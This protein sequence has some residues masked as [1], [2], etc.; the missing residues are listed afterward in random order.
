MQS[1]VS[2]SLNPSYKLTTALLVYGSAVATVHQPIVTNGRITLGKGTPL[3]EEALRDLIRTV[4]PN[5]PLE[6]FPEALLYRDTTTTVWFTHPTTQRM[7]FKTLP[8][9]NGKVF[10]Q[11]ACVWAVHSG[12]FF[13]RAVAGRRRP[14]L[15]TPLLL[16]PYYNVNG[17][18]VVCTG[19]MTRPETTT[20]E[21]LNAWIDG[22]F[23]ST[24]TH[25]NP[26]FRWKKG[27]TFQAM[28]TLAHDKPFPT[29][30][31]APSNQ[32]LHSW[33]QAIIQ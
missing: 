7:W 29:Q 20:A 31:L 22:F 14:T 33:L 19:S 2:G 32:T 15:D 18:G 11:P 21:T 30:W 23:N 12:T 13:V 6:I 17:E 10:H 25:A 16:A 3:T 1:S 27:I 9:L 8:A 26:G 24:F 5:A 4:Q 28:W